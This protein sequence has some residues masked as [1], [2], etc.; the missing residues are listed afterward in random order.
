MGSAPP[1]RATRRRP[2]PCPWRAC[3]RLATRRRAARAASSRWTRCAASDAMRRSVLRPWNAVRPT[4]AEDDLAREI[5][6]HLQL[7]EDEFVRR[8]VSAD[9]APLAAR[10]ALRSAA[11]AMDR[12][13][14]SRSFVWL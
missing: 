11:V 9:E 7:L 10:R 3:W 14:D 12:R 4:R 2:R 13:R 1:I 6:S 5:A 8:G